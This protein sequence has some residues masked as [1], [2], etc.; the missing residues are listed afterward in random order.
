[1]RFRAGRTEAEALYTRALA[2]S[3][4][5][6]GP[7]SQLTLRIMGGLGGFYCNQQRYADGEPLLAAKVAGLRRSLPDSLWLAE[8]L[9]NNGR[10]LI[11]M[12]RFDEAEATL[13]EA[14]ELPKAY[15]IRKE[16]R[17][18]ARKE[19]AI[20]ALGDSYRARGKPEPADA[21][22]TM[23]PPASTDDLGAP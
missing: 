23:L 6:N 11:R 2:L 19:R 10:V 21:Y 20:R 16:V 9:T 13:L 4:R 8:T 1:M 18:D 14:Y 5:A 17:K 3:R 12:E 15:E 7:D 22:R